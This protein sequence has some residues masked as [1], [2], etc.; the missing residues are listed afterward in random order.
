M[1]TGHSRT[2][3]A[4]LLS[5]AACTMLAQAEAQAA[6]HAQ[7]PAAGRAPTEASAQPAASYPFD[8]PA[9]DMVE[10][11]QQVAARAGLELYASAV[12]LDRL[13]APALK[14][15]FGVRAA[16]AA[17]LRGSDLSADFDGRSIVI[18]RLSSSS[19]A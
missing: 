19:A 10:A 1:T 16:I 6:A 2:F 18:R 11:L 8:M 13:E 17:L 4:A 3:I 7:T 5:S 14:G 12:D 9:Q 15:N